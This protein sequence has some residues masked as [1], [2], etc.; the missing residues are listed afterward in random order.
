MA[1]P[2]LVVLF[3]FVA[4]AC[5]GTGEADRAG[6][7]E[8]A[9]GGASKSDSAPRTLAIG[10]T[11]KAT[12]QQSIS[13]SGNKAGEQVN[14]IVSLNVL[15][16]GGQIVIPGGSTIVLTIARLQPAIGSSVADGVIELDAPTV[17]V[18][19]TTYKANASVQSVPHTLQGRTAAPADRDVIVTPGTPITITL[20]QPLSISAN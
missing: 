7:S 11:I 2:Q 5:S 15:D 14:A 1:K 19:A 17:T 16:N 4:L 10:T 13:S 6:K 9:P 8:V 20:T 18:G 3:A 12:I